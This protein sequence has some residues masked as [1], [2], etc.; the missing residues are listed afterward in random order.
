[1]QEITRPSILVIKSGGGLGNRFDPV[2]DDLAQLWHENKKWIYIHGGSERTNEISTKLGCPPQ[3]IKSSSGYRSRRTDRQTVL[4]FT[5]VYAGEINKQ[6][7]EGLQRRSVN[8]IGLCGADARLLE[9]RR[10]KMIRAVEKGR[11]VMV[12][13]DYTGTIQ[14]VN[15]NLLEQL[16]CQNYA[17]VLCPP[18]ISTEHELINV[19]GDRIAAAV[20]VALGA[21]TLILLTGASGVY[22]DFAE[23][24]SLIPHLHYNQLDQTIKNYAQGR[25]R[26]KLLATKEALSKGVETVLIAGSNQKTPI[27]SALN[28]HSGTQVN[29]L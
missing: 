12:R 13:D 6:I 26:I 21:K 4:I 29:N 1:M 9:G 2:L 28:K 20:A 22:K 23:P 3:F 10:K 11:T 16:L 25:M 15:S 27:Y 14:Q 5:M 7:V 17:P 19:D 8:A 18:A 24:T